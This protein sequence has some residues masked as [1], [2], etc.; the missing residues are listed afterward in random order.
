MSDVKNVMSNVSY[1]PDFVLLIIFCY[2][3]TYLI[4]TINKR[5]LKKE[6]SQILTYLP[7]K[8]PDRLQNNTEVLIHYIFL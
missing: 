7:Q 3:I 4:L 1:L 2:D 5:M 6:I 8:L